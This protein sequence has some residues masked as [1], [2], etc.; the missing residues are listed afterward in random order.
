MS[1]QNPYETL[2]I[3]ESASFETIQAA[4]DRRLEEFVGNTA[5]VAAVHTAYDAILMD[6]LR[7]RQ[8]GKIKV[9]DRIRF[10]EKLVQPT[11]S[12]FPASSSL[13]SGWLQQ[14]IDQPTWVD[15][16]LPASIMTVLGAGVVL[17][18]SP[19]IL[20]LAMALA[21]GSTLYLVFRK[22]KKVGRAVLLGV[23]GLVVGFALSA[24][25][26]PLAKQMP[27]LQNPEVFTS[28]VTFLVLWIVS[29]FL[30]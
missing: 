9:P 1:D 26:Y 19:A 2:G 20:Q 22:E 8:E 10:P 27:G 30:K 5:Q 28:L 11:P 6:R 18:N 12:A 15:V 14:L 24:L 3:S 7:L 23:G 4:R 25:L 29:S 13:S 21:T 17:I 16:V